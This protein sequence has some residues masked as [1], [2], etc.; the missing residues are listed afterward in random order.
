MKSKHIYNMAPHVLRD[1]IRLTFPAVE[2][3]VSRPRP[4]PRPP[5]YGHR[6]C[7]GDLPCEVRNALG[8]WLRGK[9]GAP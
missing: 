9:G 4:N 3:V 1:E 5:G 7:R 6:W 8:R 2:A